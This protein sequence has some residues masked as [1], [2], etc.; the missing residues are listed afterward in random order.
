M[1]LLISGPPGAPLTNV[2]LERF[3]SS[4]GAVYLVPTATMADHLKNSLVRAGVPVRPKSIQTFAGFLDQWSPLAAASEPSMYFA[5]E[6]AL[7]TLRPRRFEDVADFPGV[8]GALANLFGQVSGRKLSGD[9]GRIFLEAER[10]LLARNLAPRQARLDAAAQRISRENEPLPPHIFFDGFFKFSAGEAFLIAVLTNRTNVTV[11]LPDWSGA[12]ATRETFL[13][14]GFS[15]QRVPALPAAPATLLRAINIEREVEEIA[16]RILVEAEAGRPFREM[17]VIMRSQDPYGPL[18]ETTLARFGIPHR[19]Y[20][21]QPLTSHPHVQFLA[22]LCRA[23]I[24]DWDN[25]ILLH[26]LRSPAS[27]LGGTKLGDDLDFQLREQLPHYGWPQQPAWKASDRREATEWCA[28]LQTL[29]STWKP[30]LA[31]DDGANDER[32]Q[33]WRSIAAAQQAWDEALDT[34]ALELG[35]TRLTLAEFWKHTETVLKLAQLRAPDARR[36]VVHLLDAYE[37]RQWSVPVVFVC[38]LT[39][40]QFPKYHSE[41]P[42]V[43]DLALRTAGLDTA[44]DR[45]KEERFLFDLALTRATAETIL[46]YPHYDENGQNSLPSFFLEGRPFTDVSGEVRPAPKLQISVPRPSPIQDEALRQKLTEQFT[47]LSASAIERYLRCPFM[48]FA[49]RSLRAKERPAEPRDRLN[50]LLQGNIMHAAIAEWT[51]RPFLD[52]AALDGAFETLCGKERVPQTYRAEAVRLELL[53]NFESFI[54][55]TEL[56]LTWESR[57]EE[58]FDFVLRQGLSLRGRIDRLLID[59]SGRALV[60]DYKY[61]AADKLKAKVEESESGDQVQAGVYLLAAEKHF[62]LIPGGML[63]CAVKKGVHWDGWHSGLDGLQ[64]IGEKRTPQD[65][66]QLASDA[67]QN[68]LHVH[69]EITEGRIAVQPRD[70]S[71]CAWCASRDICRVESIEQAKEM[72]A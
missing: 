17:A 1:P 53:R 4:P 49:E 6:R 51:V 12:E 42:L 13:A 23:A 56:Q 31:V 50:V 19:G 43:G 7:E 47:K 35:S 21:S 48:F 9:V 60:I 55:D 63:F 69:A 44:A 40:R 67:E 58:G 45:D 22:Q 10:D 68:V 34:T 57:V 64:D 36:N 27:G 52:A 8:I 14:G 25:E 26:A 15:E 30:E 46:S 29:A 37:A 65:I 71:K 66:L 18:L 32:V 2:A 38:G 24:H 3:R 41:D 54:R 61:S 11:T 59:P 33:A 39:E 20:F 72:T 28:R 5:V 62:N 70:K 16:R